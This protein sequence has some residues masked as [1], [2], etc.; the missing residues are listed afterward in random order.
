VLSLSLSNN[1]LVRQIVLQS[2]IVNQYDWDGRL[3][4]VDEC[5]TALQYFNNSNLLTLNP[6]KAGSVNIICDLGA[7]GIEL[8]AY[9]DQ[10]GAEYRY[11]G[12][13]EVFSASCEGSA[14]LKLRDNIKEYLLDKMFGDQKHVAK[15]KYAAEMIEIMD[16]SY[17]NHHIKVHDVYINCR[18]ILTDIM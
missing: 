9:E 8:C 2:G 18:S 7:G 14:S 3:L 17:N 13:K 12:Q 11:M 6:S 10:H 1:D 4:L 15:E 16:N 5:F